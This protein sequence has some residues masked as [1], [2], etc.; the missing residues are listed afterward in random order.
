[1]RNIGKTPGVSIATVCAECGIYF[2]LSVHSGN[3]SELIH[4]TAHYQRN[5]I[6]GLFYTNRDRADR[7]T[8]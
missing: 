6:F 5:T 8:L 4:V 1:M 7:T 2:M 3:P